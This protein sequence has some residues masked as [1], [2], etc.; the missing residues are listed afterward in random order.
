MCGP[1]LT[2]CG[3]KAPIFLPFFLYLILPLYCQHFVCNVDILVHKDSWP[4]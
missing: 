1:I 3:G 4:R 2:Q